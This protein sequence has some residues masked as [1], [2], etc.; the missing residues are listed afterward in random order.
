VNVGS[1]SAYKDA[2]KVDDVQRRNTW[3]LDLLKNPTETETQK[4]A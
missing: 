3:L 4:T 1:I 2:L